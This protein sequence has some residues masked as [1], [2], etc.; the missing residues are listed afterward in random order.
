M[1]K[2]TDE[3]ILNYDLEKVVSI[4][5]VTKKE[6][7]EDYMST[8]PDYDLELLGIDPSLQFVDL[9]KFDLL[10]YKKSEEYALEN[11]EYLIHIKHLNDDDKVIERNVGIDI[12]NSGQ[13]P[14]LPIN[15]N[16]IKLLNGYPNT[17]EPNKKVLLNIEMINSD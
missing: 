16:T 6:A 12:E 17:W 9:N 8:D 5:I 11:D 3:Y 2:L 14:F 4:N 1:I 15:E 10:Y 7:I 13:A